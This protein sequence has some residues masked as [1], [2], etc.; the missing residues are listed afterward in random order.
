MCM[1]T[2]AANLS[3]MVVAVRSLA[4]RLP[5][6]YRLMQTGLAWRVRGFLRPSYEPEFRALTQVLPAAR[7]QSL[8]DVGANFGQSITAMMKTY[9]RATI[10]AFE[11]NQ[12]LASRLSRRFANSD[13]IQVH[14]VALGEEP[15][16]AILYM[17]TYNGIAFPG[18]ASLDPV[19]AHRWFSAETVRWYRE[20]H[21][22]TVALPV[23]IGRLDSYATYADL[24]KVDVEGHEVGVLAGGLRLIEAAKPALLV[25]CSG[26]FDQVCAL[27]AP[28][29]YQPL[30]LLHG[31]WV[32][33]YGRQLNQLFLASGP[34]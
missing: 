5:R 32:P 23:Q 12:E 26:T 10:L 25:E 9:P 6:L 29:R 19:G 28:F 21:F 14:P 7:V 2:D 17:P 3:P 31:R 15:G 16:G 30:E 20:D 1:T 11:P 18:L 33:S 22:R 8:I 27:L 13:G 24:I 34:A 4:L